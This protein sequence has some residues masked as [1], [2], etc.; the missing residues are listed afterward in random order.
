MCVVC[1]AIGTWHHSRQQQ[2][3]RVP[4]NQSAC[5]L[6][7]GNTVNIEGFHV[8][9]C[10]TVTVFSACK[11]GAGRPP[12]DASMCVQGASSTVVL[13][14]ASASEAA[15]NN[16]SL[17][18]YLCVQNKLVRL[19][20]P[21]HIIYKYKMQKHKNT[22]QLKIHRFWNIWNFRKHVFVIVSSN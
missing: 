16:S 4:S 8:R 17:V 7:G 21:Q 10:T 19:C 22:T 18:P 5:R 12:A 3:G 15:L 13:P 6:G 1:V 2:R 9:P 14:L 20:G 11:R